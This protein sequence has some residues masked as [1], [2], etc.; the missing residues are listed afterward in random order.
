MNKRVSLN[1]GRTAPD[2]WLSVYWPNEAMKLLEA[3][4]VDEVSLD[5]DPGEDERRT[6]Y[7]VVSGQ[8]LPT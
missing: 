4:T 5:H 3:E 7:D 6:G 8:R 1:D 2:G